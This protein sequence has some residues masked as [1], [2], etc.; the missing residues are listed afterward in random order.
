MC[1][2]MRHLGYITAEVFNILFQHFEHSVPFYS[3]TDLGAIIPAFITLWL[4]FSN[5][6][7]VRLPLIAVPEG[8]VDQETSFPRGMGPQ[9]DNKLESG[10][11]LPLARKKETEMIS[12]HHLELQFCLNKNHALFIQQV[13][14]I[15][16][17]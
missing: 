1:V 8:S 15:L 13:F 7:Y 3:H 4:N 11:L 5:V 9:E 12:N 2:F 17:P 14:N 6:L 10:F 16:I